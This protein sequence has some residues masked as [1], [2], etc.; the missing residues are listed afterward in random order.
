M[1]INFLYK[2][3]FWDNLQPGERFLG[4]R[5]QKPNPSFLGQIGNAVLH[6]LYVEG[7]TIHLDPL[8]LN[9]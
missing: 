2:I 6:T 9:G 8:F 4:S 7:Y 1:Y 5:D 3:R